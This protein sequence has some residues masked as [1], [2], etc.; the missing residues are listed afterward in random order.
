MKIVVTG[1]LGHIGKPLTQQLVQSGHNVTVISSKSEKRAEIEALGATA[2]IGIIEDVAFLTATFTGA[3][4]V[5]TMIPPPAIWDPAI[6]MVELCRT[7]AGNFAAAITQSGVKRLVHLSSIGAH[8]EKDSGLIRVHH[9]AEKVL[10]KLSGVGIT[11]MRPTAFYYN[12]LSFIPGIKSM[13]AIASN[14]GG[15]DV[16]SWVSPKDIATAVADEI[17]TP[18]TGTK[19][20]Y[21]ASE[22]LPCSQVASILGAAIGKPDLQWVV[23]TNEQLQDGMESFGVPKSV[24]A[25]LVEMNAS[26]HNGA[27]FADYYQ[28]RPELGS[29]KLPEYAKE[30]AAAYNK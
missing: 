1:S 17:T 18:L 12:L 3:D 2:A 4:A 15:D 24:A 10:S 28:H 29:T 6:D 7:L 19:V 27:L 21:V 5:Y 25:G 26:M 11:F 30:F 13:G 16:I 14:Y 9:E 22:E 20:R 23:I 8:M